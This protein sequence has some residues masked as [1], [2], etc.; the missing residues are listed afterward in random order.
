[1]VVVKVCVNIVSEMPSTILGTFWASVNVAF[2]L[3]SSTKRD[4]LIKLTMFLSY[5]T[6]I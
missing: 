4:C 6:R 3:P 1:M 2:L 5:I